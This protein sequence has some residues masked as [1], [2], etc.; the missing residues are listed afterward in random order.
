MS[1]WQAYPHCPSDT[2]V[3]LEKAVQ[4][5]PEVYLA[6]LCKGEE[7]ESPETCLRRLQGYTLSQRF[8]VVQK[9]GSLK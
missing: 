3:K 5:L 2:R 7:F 6:P 4:A 9:S 1:S 8:A